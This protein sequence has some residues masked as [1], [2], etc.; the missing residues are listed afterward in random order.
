MKVKETLPSLTNDEIDDVWLESLEEEDQ[1]EEIRAWFLARYEDPAIETPYDSEAG[2][3][4]FPWGGPYDPAEVL[5]D[6]FALV[7][8]DEVIGR[9][10]KELYMH[11]GEAWAPKYGEGFSY[12]DAFG[13]DVE[14]RDDPLRA[15]NLRLNQIDGTFELVGN[16]N[17]RPLL[18]QL[19]HG[20][21]ISALEAYLWDTTMYW[22][23][24]EPAVLKSFVTTNRDFRARKLELGDI[25]RRME[26]LKDEVKVYFETFIW[27]RLDKVKEVLEPGLKIRMPDIA[28]LMMEIV[29]RH[30][31]VHRAGRTKNGVPVAITSKDAKDTIELVRSFVQKVEIELLNRFPRDEV[32]DLPF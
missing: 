3:Y 10:V 11:G 29:K 2:E 25:F 24:K 17:S 23:S 21:A 8:P 5:A 27:H 18:N 16:R 6:R 1:I 22:L 7:V 32:I 4:F 15:L 14:D 28:P 30:D 31:V 9:L 19:A 20:A 13:T 26:A 12:D